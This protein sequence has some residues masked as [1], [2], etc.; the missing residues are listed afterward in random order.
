MVNQAN[1]KL[2]KPMK[3]QLLATFCYGRV[4]LTLLNERFFLVLIAIFL[5]N[6]M[7]PGT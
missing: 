1:N 2:I 5:L 4:N 7:P 3:N 6:V